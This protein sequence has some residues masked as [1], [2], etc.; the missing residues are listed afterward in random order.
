M[1]DYLHQSE[2]YNAEKDGLPCVI[3]TGRGYPSISTRAFIQRLVE[4]C[5]N[6][7]TGHR[8]FSQVLV[9][10]DYNP[11]G[12]KIAMT[13]RGE[14]KLEGKIKEEQSKYVLPNVEVRDHHFF[15]LRVPL[16][17]MTSLK[18]IK[19]GSFKKWHPLHVTDSSSLWNNY[20]ASCAQVAWHTFTRRDG[21]RFTK[22]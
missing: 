15:S 6:E 14:V 21:F 7:K 19:Q 16:L 1:F 20:C 22:E 4:T 18:Q 8:H 12:A 2:F 3:I 11:D 13:Y 9:L 5:V 10:T 17:S